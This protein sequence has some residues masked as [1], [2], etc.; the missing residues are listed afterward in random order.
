ME[1]AGAPVVPDAAFTT[2]FFMGLIV[3]VT[4]ANERNLPSFAPTPLRTRQASGVDSL[5]IA[6]A[7]LQLQIRL[8]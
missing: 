2:K 6:A 5:F 4:A 8:H 1:R 7:L 3:A